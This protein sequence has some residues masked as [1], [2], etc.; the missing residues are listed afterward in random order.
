MEPRWPKMEQHVV[1]S[2]ACG[3]DSRQVALAELLLQRFLL[4]SRLQALR[5]RRVLG[6]DVGEV[7]HLAPS[8]SELPLL[9]AG[10]SSGRRQ[11][12]RSKKKEQE[13]NQTQHKKK[14]IYTNSRST[15]LRGPILILYIC[16]YIYI[17][18]ILYVLF[19]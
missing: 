4:G 14:S 11:K 17:Y 15:A 13:P 18:I 3:W 9:V 6:A 12:H 10:G 1:L 16:I 7:R 5:R 19:S 2:G 8:V